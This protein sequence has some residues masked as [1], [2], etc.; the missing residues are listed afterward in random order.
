MIHV[1]AT[2]FGH[3]RRAPLQ[4]V[5]L[6]AGLALATALWS[7]VQ[8]INAE[9]RASYERA[10]ERLGTGDMAALT[11]PEG[12]IALETYVRLRRAGWQLSPVLE[13]VWGQGEQ[14]VTLLGVDVLSYPGAPAM[15][16]A[17]ETEGNLD[18]AGLLMTPGVMFANPGTRAKLERDDQ[19]AARIFSLPDL[20]PDLVLSDISV[21]EAL[22]N[23]PGQLSRLLILP[24]QPRD[25]PPLSA[26]APGL[27]VT[28]TNDGPLGD[29]GRLTRSFHL[30]L[31]A[32]G[33]LSFGVGLFIVQGSIM[34]SI[35]QRRGTIRTLRCLGVSVSSLMTALLLELILLALVAGAVGLVVGYSLAGL[36]LPDVSATLRGLYGAPVDG[37][38]SLRLSWVLSG[39]GMALAGTLLAGLQALISL[40]RLA[41]HL[42]QA[43]YA[44]A[45]LSASQIQI[46][47]LSGAGLIGLGAVVLS[48]GSGLLAGFVGLGGLMLGSAVLVLPVLNLLLQGARRMAGSPELQWLAADS[49]LQLPGLS[50]SLMALLLAVATN[51]GVGTMV[52]SFRM[53]FVDWIDQRLVA[54]VFVEVETEAQAQSVLRW[55]TL[56]RARSLPQFYSDTRLNSA[57]L[58]IYGVVDDPLYREH[59]PLVRKT[60]DAWER[61]HGGGAV[62]VN[63]QLAQRDGVQVGDRMTV[64]PGWSAPV[65]AVYSD[66]GN[67][68]KQII[69]SLPAL[70]AQ[71][72]SPTLLRIGL[73]PP[74]GMSRDDLA[75]RL[76][77]DL[78][79]TRT[80]I[81][82][83]EAIKSLSIAV[84]DRTFVVTGA[85]NIL[86]LAVAGFA[87][88]T[89]FL[90]QWT[91]RLP[92]LAPVWAMG[93]SRARLAG[94][95]FL[96]SLGFAILTF[97]FALPLGLGLAWV[98]LNVINLEAFG[99]RLPMYLFPGAWARL[100]LLTC[101]A[102]GLAALTPVLRLLRLAPAQ[103]LGVFS[104]DRP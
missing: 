39:L 75:Q 25:L 14:S 7:A 13:G 102:A 20:P 87:M 48:F 29:P 58:R 79:I 23:R 89:S 3:W 6:I 41:R 33:F 98:L 63:E 30:N 35:E 66:Y 69:A 19:E 95:E 45:R 71:V 76:E 43:S 16:A 44:P 90:S 34:L 32:F 52:S 55:A 10:V 27:V 47:C 74:E 82:D 56:L 31:T 11:S 81:R 22:L 50:L 42:S 86:T 96:R 2:M 84:F 24:D 99:W 62:F 36:L 60:P 12:T 51:V 5:L 85:L 77:Q 17:A 15:A 54:D 83:K 8:A 73:V 38:L 46:L 88:L 21:V 53:T 97:V 28:A 59:W 37:T 68:D 80:A 70:R 67:P 72:P 78:D 26:R 101:L 92:Q 64:G 9:A 49:R 91:R 4:L 93:I 57:P 61:L 40:R 100:L 103:L 94:L 65:A 18:V 1:L 104:N